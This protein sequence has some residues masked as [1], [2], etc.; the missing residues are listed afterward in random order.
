MVTDQSE[1]VVFVFTSDVFDQ[2]RNKHIV[3]KKTW[4]H[5]K[6]QTQYLLSSLF[7]HIP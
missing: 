7:I 3:V 1:V 2:D 5:A 4:T 6:S